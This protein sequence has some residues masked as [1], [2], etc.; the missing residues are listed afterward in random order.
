MFKYVAILIAIIVGLNLLTWASVGRDRILLQAPRFFDY[1]CPVI[2]LDTLHVYAGYLEDVESPERSGVGA[3]S[4][5]S[6]RA[7]LDSLA[8]R[9]QSIIEY[10][11]TAV[12]V[13]PDSPEKVHFGVWIDRRY[14]FYAH[15]MAGEAALGFG[16]TYDQ[17]WI[18]AFGWWP[19]GF[20]RG[21]CS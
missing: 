19:V 13:F 20:A 8:N 6:R 21:G 7:L 3:F 11:D 12:E 15:L 16:A 18:W 10:H 9:S 17:D 5:H 14:P 4:E 2:E 1:S